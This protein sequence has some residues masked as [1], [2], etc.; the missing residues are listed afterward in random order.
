VIAALKAFIDQAPSEVAR[1]EAENVLG[2]LTEQG[3]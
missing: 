3:G 2:K 1:E